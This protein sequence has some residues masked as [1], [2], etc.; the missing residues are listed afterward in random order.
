MPPKRKASGTIIADKTTAVITRRSLKRM[1]DSASDYENVPATVAEFPNDSQPS[2]E[3]IRR[4]NIAKI[5]QEMQHIGLSAA[6]AA[7]V[8]VS[9]IQINR[10]SNAA[11]S[12]V[13]RSTPAVEPLRMSLRAR[14]GETMSKRDI[15]S[16]A[17]FEIQEQRDRMQRRPAPFSVEDSWYKDL[18]SS[19]HE[20]RSLSQGVFAALRRA[21]FIK[22]SVKSKVVAAADFYGGMQVHSSGYG[23]LV[24]DRIYSICMH[25]SRDSIIGFVG[26]KFGNALRSVRIF[27]CVLVSL[28][29]A[30]R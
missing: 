12:R 15:Y 5:Q 4:R 16:E 28:I 19:H 26:D 29:F 11:A 9:N 30:A 21:S 18:G 20:S 6:A 10:S 27:I 23:K 25:P 2:Y 7:F 22:S 13:K 3:D 14:D 1:K 24:P 8:P 17:A